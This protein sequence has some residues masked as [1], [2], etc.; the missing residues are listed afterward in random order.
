MSGTAGNRHAVLVGLISLGVV[1]LATTVLSAS[2][3]AAPSK[4]YSLVICALPGS[5]TCAP[6]PTSTAALPAAVPAG[7]A[8]LAMT[9]T[10]TNENKP[11]TGITLGSANLTPPSG[12]TV[13]GVDLR[14]RNVCHGVE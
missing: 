10:L 11:G 1:V 8:N 4:P 5:E 7:A 6:T 13:T 12:F 14:L 3:V 2:A 9:A